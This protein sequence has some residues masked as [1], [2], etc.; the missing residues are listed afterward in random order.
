MSD[1]PGEFRSLP[2]EDAIFSVTLD[3]ALALLATPKPGRRSGKESAKETSA[4]AEPVVS[5]GEYE[6]ETLAVYNGRYG[7]YG[8]TRLTEFHDSL[9]DEKECDCSQRPYQRTDDCNFQQV[10]RSPKK[11]C[12][13]GE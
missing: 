3:E 12:V 8:K 6:G 11:V 5:F 7:F 10:P 4:N 1:R 13:P 2:N 9:S